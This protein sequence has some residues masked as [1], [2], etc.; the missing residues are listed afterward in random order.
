M[1]ACAAATKV[2]DIFEQD[3]IL[4]NVNIVGEYLY[5]RLEDVKNRYPQIVDH[6][7]IGLIQGLEFDAP[8]GPVISKMLDNGLITFAAGSN[9]I[10]FIPPLI[11][12][13]ENVDEMIEKLESC[14]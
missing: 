12:T 11:I 14:L 4:D 13:K 3:N 7:G 2:F 5:E 9:V 1:L 6:R 8:V 10:R